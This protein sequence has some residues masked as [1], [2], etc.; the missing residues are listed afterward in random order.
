MHTHCIDTVWS[1]LVA[2]TPGRHRHTSRLSCT[3]S[4]PP[5]RVF[6]SHRCFPQFEGFAG[7]P[8]DDHT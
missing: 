7:A 5:H 2:K 3:Q 6:A 4:N 1:P 8:T